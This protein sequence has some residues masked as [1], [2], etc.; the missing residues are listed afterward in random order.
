MAAKPEQQEP[1]TTVAGVINMSTPKKKRLIP[2]AGAELQGRPIS[3]EVKRAQNARKL[4]QEGFTPNE[5][6]I[7]LGVSVRIIEAIIGL[8]KE[9]SYGSASQ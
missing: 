6:A 7:K 4:L 9:A 8:G 1:R 5:V 2:Y 3:N